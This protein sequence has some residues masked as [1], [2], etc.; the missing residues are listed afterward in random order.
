LEGEKNAELASLRGD[1]TKQMTSNQDLE[2]EIE[3]MKHINQRIAEETD[4]IQLQKSRVERQA[5][6]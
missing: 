5:Q 3:R 1:T 4:E 2:A 6:D